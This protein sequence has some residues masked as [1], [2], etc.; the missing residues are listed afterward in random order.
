MLVARVPPLSNEGILCVRP[1]VGWNWTRT[2]EAIT[3]GWPQRTRIDAPARVVLACAAPKKRR[4]RAGEPTTPPI[5][6]LFINSNPV[7][8]RCF[9]CRMKILVKKLL[10]DIYIIFTTSQSEDVELI[11]V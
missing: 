11:G 7:R 3:S 8:F 10:K 1:G 9:E 6:P 5:D 4:G 2:E